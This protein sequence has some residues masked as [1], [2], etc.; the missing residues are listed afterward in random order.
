VKKTVSGVLILLA[1]GTLAYA[2]WGFPAVP[3]TG[4]GQLRPHVWVRGYLGPNAAPAPA[5]GVTP[6][7]MIGAYDIN[8][9]SGQG[10]TVAIVDAYDSPNAASDLA[11]FS[12]NFGITC[13]T[14]GGTFTKVNESGA[15]RPLPVHNSGWEVEINLDTQWVHA[16]A[17]CANIVLVEANSN[18]YSDLMTA[19]RTAATLGSVVSMSWGGGEFSGQT[20]YDSYFVKSGVTFLASSG[21]TGGVVEY[22]SSSINVIG[23]GGTNLSLNP[24]GSVASETAWNGSGGGCSTIEPAIAAQSGFVPLPCLHRATPDVAMDG[25]NLSP[26][27]VYI[28]DQG[29]WF[30]VYGTSL[31]VQLWAAVMATANGVSSAPLNSVLSDL[32]TAA[33]GAPSSALYAD[34]YRDITSGTAGNFSAGLGWDFITGLGTPLV[35]SLVPSLGAP[36][37][38]PQPDFSVSV[39]PSQQVVQGNTSGLYTLTETPINGFTGTVSWSFGTLPAGITATPTEPTSGTFTLTAAS[40]LSAGSYSIPVTG[41]SGSLVHSVNATLVVTAK[42]VTTPAYTLSI[43]PTSQT[44]TRPASGTKMVTY[45]VYVAEQPGFTNVV[46][47]SVSGG[48]TGVNPTVT[49]TVQPGGMGTLTVTVSASAKKAST[50]LTVTSSSTGI[51]SKTATAI[52]QVN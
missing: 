41:T 24:N 5:G 28:S 36:A 17:P 51:P 13:Q 33:A 22:P 42:V 50:T 44:V 20:S 14:G 43:M 48:T 45:N 1:A 16:I 8:V 30:S 31:A 40:S 27:S 3:R 21:D 26:V 35:N 37:P 29:G 4:Q 6:A 32:Y 9:G 12:S 38:P 19:V 34:N 15:S 10:A 49:G 47:L 11:A 52:V 7:E 18:S 25:G 39:S 2:Q 23:V 46:T